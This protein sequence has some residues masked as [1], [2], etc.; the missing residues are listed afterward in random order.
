[1][2]PGLVNI[3]PVMDCLLD[4]YGHVN[5]LVRICTFAEKICTY[6]VHGPWTMEAD[7]DSE[8]HV[9]RWVGLSEI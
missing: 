5:D 2:V 6:R 1:L 3:Q 9:E 7:G 4:K 8:V